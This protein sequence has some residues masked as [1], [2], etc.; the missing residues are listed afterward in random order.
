MRIAA[1]SAHSALVSIIFKKQVFAKQVL[2]FDSPTPLP[3]F[4]DIDI[5][6]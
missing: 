1:C 5:S 2:P 6:I 4:I 3:L